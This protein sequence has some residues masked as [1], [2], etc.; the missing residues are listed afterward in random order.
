MKFNFHSIAFRT[1]AYIFSFSL[2]FILFISLSAKS[3]FSNAYIDL[4]KEKINIIVNAIKPSIAINLSYGFEDGIDE[5]LNKTLENS[6]VLLLEVQNHEKNDTKTFTNSKN[7]IDNYRANNQLI[8][9][10]ELLDPATQELLGKLTIVYSKDAYEKY[11][12]DFYKWLSFGI[13]LFFVAVI[14]LLSF[15]YKSLSRLTLLDNSLKKFDPKK[16]KKL[17]LTASSKDEISSI[18]NSANLMIKNIILFLDSLKS[19]NAE[20]SQSQDH[21][22]DAQRMAKV[23]SW[24]YDLLTKE[25]SLSDEYYRM[26]GV[27]LHNEITW[28]NF[29]EFIHKDDYERVIHIIN[30]AIEKGSEFEIKYT[31]VLTNQKVLHIQ[32]KGKVRKKQSGLI[33]ITGISMDITNEVENKKIIEQLA[34]YDPLT[35]L[36]N[37]TL[38]NDRMLKSLQQ[39]KRSQEQLAVIFLDLDHFK[40]INDTLGHSVGDELLIY[41]SQLLQKQIREADTLSRLGGDEFVILLPNI[42]ESADAT[43]IAKKIQKALQ[44]KHHIGTHELYI[45]SSIGVSIYPQDGEDSD[46]LIRNADTAMYEA[47]NDG[48]N[49][50]KIYAQSMGN[51]IDKQLHLEQDLA[52]AVKGKREIEVFFQAKIDA[53]TEKISGA[54]ALVRWRHPTKG[55]IFPDDFIYM[56]ESTGLMI[57]LGNLITESSIAYIK[58]L[59]E[60]GYYDLKIAIN[61]SARQFQDSSL[62]P[63]ISQMLQKYKVDSSQVEFEITE[64]ISMK[65]MTATLRILSELKALGVSIAIDD[66]GTGHSSLA[67]LKKFPIDTLK[68]DKSFVMDIIDD[69]EDRV[70]AQTIISMAHSLGMKTVAEG[71]ETKEHVKML[72]NMECNILQGYFYSKA[73]T[74]DAFTAFLKEYKTN[75]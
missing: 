4:E 21:L 31:I 24:N 48:R 64:S 62:V 63:F 72:Q 73:I 58:E 3:I 13:F 38:L 15:L 23:G 20:L 53:Q 70:I 26:L 22:K 52:D 8:K 29:L 66:F 14:L 69:E 12:K 6:N 16:P 7:T 34:Y 27:N 35:G 28:R 11:M 32:T 33:K 30:L 47:K 10:I 44:V 74:K 67:Y 56:A 75:N 39:A 50:F 42:K 54:E 5:V 61:L 71:V 68:I 37:R 49:K 60:L 18:S 51:F 2:L 17:N 41:I 40:L 36:A 55:L 46:T 57:E 25:F 9:D 59:N 19:L 1:I 43:S 65:N 45:T